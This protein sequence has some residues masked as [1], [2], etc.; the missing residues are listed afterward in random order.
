MTTVEHADTQYDRM[1]DRL[2]ERQSALDRE[3]QDI[4]D[5]ALHLADGKRVYVN[6]KGRLVDRNGKPLDGAEEA[7]AKSL[8]AQRNGSVATWEDYRRNEDKRAVNDRL[9]QRV[10]QEKQEADDFRK[11]VQEHGVP[12]T[13]EVRKG[14][15]QI[16]KRVTETQKLVDQAYSHAAPSHVSTA[17]LSDLDGT[18]SPAASAATVS[19]ASKLAP[20]AGIKAVNLTAPFNTATKEATPMR[21]APAEQRPA[22]A[23]P[24]PGA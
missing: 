1:R 2:A 4:D 18:G 20:D 13:K 3:A 11:R 19:Y 23:T 16:Q 14:D 9:T 12:D 6:G 8:A 21:A 24:A 5:H 15:K 10:E 7:E 17:D 22:P